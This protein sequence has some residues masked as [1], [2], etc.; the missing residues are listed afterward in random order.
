MHA[1]SLVCVLKFATRALFQKY[2]GAFIRPFL[3]WEIPE[4]HNMIFVVFL[5]AGLTAW[6]TVFGMIHGDLPF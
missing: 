3:I 5:K 1:C 2:F 4:E 6:I